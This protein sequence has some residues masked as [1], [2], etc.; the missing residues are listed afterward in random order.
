MKSSISAATRRRAASLRHH[1]LVHVPKLIQV[2]MKAGHGRKRTDNMGWHDVTYDK[3]WCNLITWWF[4]DKKCHCR[5]K[6]SPEVFAGGRIPP[7]CSRTSR[8]AML[9]KW[10]ADFNR[11]MSETNL[12]AL[13]KYEKKCIHLCMYVC[14]SVCMYVCLYVCM[15]VCL[16]VC[17]YVCL[18][19]CRSVG[20]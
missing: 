12:R 15:S 17:M 13:T 10:P 6:P 14:L 9:Y 7:T 18:S 2:A 3:M 19:V 16:C 11:V 5:C 4:G 1:A 20:R 8:C